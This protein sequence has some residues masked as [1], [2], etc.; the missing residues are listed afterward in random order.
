MLESLLRKGNAHR[1]LVSWP[2]AFGAVKN[3]EKENSG[4]EKKKRTLRHAGS[5]LGKDLTLFCRYTFCCFY[6]VCMH[7][8][9]ISG[10]GLCLYSDRQKCVL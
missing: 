8:S 3:K 6:A 10:L 1:V 4:L 7:R 2:N 9:L 5:S